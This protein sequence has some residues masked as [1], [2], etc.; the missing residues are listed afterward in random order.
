MRLRK[1]KLPEVVEARVVAMTFAFT[2]GEFST[3]TGMPHMAEIAI[4]A[5][6]VA[7]PDV[8]HYFI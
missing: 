3:I 6:T 2:A 7:H 4:A 5:A 8:C 1:S